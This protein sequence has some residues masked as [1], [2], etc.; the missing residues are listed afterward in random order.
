MVAS[1]MA[2]GRSRDIPSGRQHFK[3]VVELTRNGFEMDDM[4]VG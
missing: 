2:H 4:V 3:K 1:L